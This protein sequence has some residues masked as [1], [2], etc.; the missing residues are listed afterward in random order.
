MPSWAKV[1]SMP[2]SRLAVHNRQGS[3]SHHGAN[4]KQ[5][6]QAIMCSSLTGHEMQSA[7]HFSL[8]AGLLTHSLLKSDTGNVESYCLH[9]WTAHHMLLS[10]LH[11]Q[12]AIESTE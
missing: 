8:G 5:Y 9:F 1:T 4:E 6:G 3:A 2:N 10:S 11:L 7:R 12:S